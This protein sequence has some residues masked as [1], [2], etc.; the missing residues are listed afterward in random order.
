MKC[1]ALPFPASVAPFRP[2]PP[3]LRRMTFPRLNNPQT[4]GRLGDGV[5]DAISGFDS[6]RGCHKGDIG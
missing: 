4:E 5:F 2:L 3:K 1:L 6:N